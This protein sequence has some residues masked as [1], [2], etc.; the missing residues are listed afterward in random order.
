[1]L[2]ISQER[3]W[4]GH[5]NALSS[6]SFRPQP[7]IPFHHP[8]PTDAE[9]VDNTK[10]ATDKKKTYTNVKKLLGEEKVEDAKKFEN[11]MKELNRLGSRPSDRSAFVNAMKC[12]ETFAHVLAL[13]SGVE[14]GISTGKIRQI[15]HDAPDV[16]TLSYT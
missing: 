11:V 6:F 4:V 12:C 1:M 7:F 13:M 2:R 14:G 9:H 3:A 10:K 15:I 8:R 16:S 5:P